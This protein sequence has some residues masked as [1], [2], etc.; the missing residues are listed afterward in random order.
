M[1]VEPGKQPREGDELNPTARGMREA[2]PYVSA[3]WQLVGG[4]VVGVLGG[5][6]LDRWL[7]T[8]PWGLVGL[9]VVGI[10]VGFTAFLK[11]MMRMGGQKR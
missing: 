6:G 4:A 9:S 8:R 7:G 10:A 11:T 5:M 3:V 1:A 2:Q